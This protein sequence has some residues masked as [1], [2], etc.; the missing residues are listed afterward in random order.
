MTLFHSTRNRDLR[1][2]LGTAVL[3]GLAPDGGLYMPCDI[4]PLPPEFFRDAPGMTFNGIAFHVLRALLAEDMDERLL[5]SIIESAFTFDAPLAPLGGRDYALE[6]FHGP[7]LAFKDFAAAFMAR[8]MAHLVRG[9]GRELVILVATS[10]DTG[11]AVAH[12]FYGVEGTRVVLLYPSGRVSGLQ[13]K[14]LASSG[15]NVAALEVSGTF[16]DCQRMVKAAFSDTELRERVMISSANSISIARLAPQAIYYFSAWA[17]RRDPSRSLVFSVPSG[18]LGN[19]TGGLLAKRLGLPVKKFVAAENANDSLVRYLENGKYEP[20]PTVRTLSNAMDVGDP[21]NFERIT[22]LYNGSVEELRAD[23]AAWSFSDEETRGAIRVLWRDRGCRA[24]PHGAVG[25][26]GLD[27]Y[28]RQTGD[29]ESDAVF[30]E[31]AHPVKF[32]EIVEEETGVPVEVPARLVPVLEREKRSIRIRA[33][34]GDLKR[35]LL[36]PRVPIP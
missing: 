4:R 7:T 11:S 12:G 36:E 8:L 35:F 28:R 29:A 15:G 14:Q 21:G 33:E 24:D 27:M 25:W 18:N 2:D 23:L 9:L 26:L 30:L 6:L 1:V 34:Y 13:E 16:D 32:R 5:S 31:T 3:G 17:R 19:L 10:G 20:R 22:A